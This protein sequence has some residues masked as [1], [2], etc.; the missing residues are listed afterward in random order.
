MPGPSRFG[1]DAGYSVQRGTLESSPY[2]GGNALHDSVQPVYDI[3]GDSGSEGDQFQ[4]Q[5][6]RNNRSYTTDL[7][8]YNNASLASSQRFS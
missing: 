7:K 3:G 5:N 1:N 8:R 2:L 4:L 6:D